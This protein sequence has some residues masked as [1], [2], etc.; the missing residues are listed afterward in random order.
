MATMMMELMHDLQDVHTHHPF[1]DGRVIVA[2]PTTSHAVE[3][4]EVGEVHQDGPSAG[5]APST[6]SG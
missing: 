5:P 3:Q 4:F 1:D 6:P 2:V